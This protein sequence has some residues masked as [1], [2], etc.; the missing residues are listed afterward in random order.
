MDTLRYGAAKTVASLRSASHKKQQ[1][2]DKKI[3]SDTAPLTSECTSHSEICGC[4]RKNGKRKVGNTVDKILIAKCRLS[5]Q[6]TDTRS[7]Y[8]STF[9]PFGFEK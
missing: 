6:P 4:A 5:R 7:H 1:Q 3:E 2:Q 9:L 8:I